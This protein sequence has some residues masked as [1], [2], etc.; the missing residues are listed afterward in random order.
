[1][2]SRNLQDVPL[3]TWQWRD[4]LIRLVLTAIIFSWGILLEVCG[5]Q[6]NYSPELQY[7]MS[8]GSFIV[9]II[10]GT[11]AQSTLA[12]MFAYIQG[13]FLLKSHGIPLHAIM[14]GEQT[15]GRILSACFVIYKYKRN[16]TEDYKKQ[17]YGKFYQILLYAST[18]FVYFASVGVGGYASSKLGTPYVYFSTPIK[19]AQVSTI[20]DE[21]LRASLNN[22]FLPNNFL[23]AISSI[24]FNSLARWSQMTAVNGKEVVFL[25]KTYNNIDIA[26]KDSKLKD[27]LLKWRVEVKYDNINMQYITAQCDVDQHP[28]CADQLEKGTSLIYTKVSKEN[29]TFLWDICNLPNDAGSVRLICSITLKEGIFPSTTIVIPEILPRSEQLIEFLLRKNEMKDLNELRDEIF[30]T[31]ENVYA[32]PSYDVNRDIITINVIQQLVNR[33]NCEARNVTCAQ[34]M[35]IAAAIRSFGARLESAN[36][37]YPSDNLINVNE[38][39]EKSTSTG[40]V[41]VTHKMCIGGTNPILTIGLMIFIPL[42]MTIIELL[43]LLFS[44]NKAWWLASDIGFKHIALLRSTAKSNINLPECT[45][46]PDET[47]D[48]QTIVR[49][50]AEPKND[51]FGLEEVYP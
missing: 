43:P 10:L 46:R 35:G 15:P 21:K 48:G 37:L 31:M 14:S 40:S 45:N 23:G 47:A 32:Q 49:F 42:L 3:A 29:K 16:S 44:N 25:P 11:L 18:L 19:W 28:P 26:V 8:F 17:K 22:A 2:S 20:P 6:P 13:Y 24:Q 34:E 12:H 38:F 50:N 5:E 51:Y 36:I 1:M 30:A 27:D 4:S 39:V 33:W 7:L 41:T 9:A